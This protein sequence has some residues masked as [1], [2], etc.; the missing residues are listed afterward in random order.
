[1]WQSV[2]RVVAGV[3][4]VAVTIG[5][6]AAANAA[7]IPLAA[8]AGDTLTLNVFLDT[9]GSDVTGFDFLLALPTGLNATQASLGGLVPEGSATAFLLDADNNL[10]DLPSTAIS[11]SAL[12]SVIA[13]LNAPAVVSG[14]G[15]LF[16]I[17]FLSSG[18]NGIL[19]L[20][21]SLF[22][23]SLLGAAGEE[24]LFG[25]TLSSIGNTVTANISVGD[26]GGVAP[27]P[28]PATVL[29]VGSG[30]AM[31]LTARRRNRKRE[32]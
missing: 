26:S 15:L 5:A 16:T 19:E 23:P 22:G 4:T 7:M 25:L 32:N 3:A 31:A 14:A 20:G 10:I 18:V 21:P 2:C 6:P 28:E 24:L 30:L 1:M 12:F 9:A 11:P 8:A 13:S 17:D 27:I 29:L